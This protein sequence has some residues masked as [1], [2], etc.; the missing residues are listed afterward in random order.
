M[1]KLPRHTHYPEELETS[2]PPAPSID[3]IPVLD[4]ARMAFQ[5]WTAFQSFIQA[6]Y[7]D[8]C[9]VLGSWANMVS[10]VLGKLTLSTAQFLT[11]TWDTFYA[12]I[13]S[14]LSA[15]TSAGTIATGAINT[16]E[17]M[18]IGFFTG[19]KGLAKFATG[20]F[21]AD[22]TGRGKFAELFVN[23]ALIDNLAVTEAKIGNLAVT[24]A[25]IDNLAVTEA[26]IADLNVTTA[27]INNLAVTDAKINDLDAAKII[28]GT[29]VA[30]KLYSG[31]IMAYRISSSQLRTDVAI[32][33]Q[34]VMLNDL[35]VTSGK[36]AELLGIKSAEVPVIN[37]NEY[38][39]SCT[40]LKGQTNTCDWAD[41]NTDCIFSFN[42]YTY[43]KH[44]LNTVTVL[45][46]VEANAYVIS[47]TTKIRCMY[48]TDGT[49]WYQF[50]SEISLGNVTTTYSLKTFSQSLLTGLNSILK[51]KLQGYIQVQAGADGVASLSIY[52]KEFCLRDRA[53]RSQRGDI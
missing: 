15:I 26:K 1:R 24:N 44:E 20:L 46:R 32:I 13:S 9:A 40:A 27:K 3:S 14:G 33:T 17:Q 48:T 10:T 29:I 52:V 28:A 47:G 7:T 23:E 53:F 38:V 35:V 41:I 39:M 34:T 5:T 11:V 36:L 50:G 2:Y 16:L 30:S 19:V 51:V 22:V 4:W 12:L 45:A 43:V 8:F 42:A 25:K 31:D 18:A 6:T 49:N 37:I 21:T